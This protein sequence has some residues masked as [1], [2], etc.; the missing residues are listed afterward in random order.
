MLYLLLKDTGFINYPYTMIWGEKDQL[1]ATQEFIE[2]IIR[3]TFFRHLYVH[4][5]ELETTQMFIACGTKLWLWLCS[6]NTPQPGHI[7][8]NHMP[9]L[10]STITK[11]MCHMLWTSV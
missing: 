4:H 1:D 9:N 7:S 2:L 11:V 6:S 3:S 10:Q 5:Q 8:Y